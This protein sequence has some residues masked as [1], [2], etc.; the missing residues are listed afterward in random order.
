MSIAPQRPL[1][2]VD[3]FRHPTI[4]ELAHYLAQGD[5]NG[6]RNHT[7]DEDQRIITNA[8][9]RVNKQKDA[10]TRRRQLVQQQV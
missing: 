10:R 4:N 3:L 6:L 7:G 9:D 1:A 8:Q 2:V 5:D